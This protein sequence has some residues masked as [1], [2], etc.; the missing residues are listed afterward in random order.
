[1]NKRLEIL[2]HIAIWIV[3]ILLPLMFMNHGRGMSV[4]QFML[5]TTVPLTFM[6]VFYIDYLWLTPRYFVTGHRTQFFVI[7]TFIV[8]VLGIALHLWMSLSHD[9]LGHNHREPP[10]IL[11]VAFV[12]RDIVNLVIAAAIA[13][14]L[15]LALQWQTAE[16]ARKE[17]ELSNLRSQINPHFLLNTLNNIYALT[18]INTQ[19]AQEAIQDLSKMLR[20]MLYDYQRSEIELRD[21]VEFLKNYIRLMKL[22]QGP[23]VEVNTSF[24]ITNEQQKVAPMIFI[25]LVENAFKHGVKPAVPCTINITIQANDRQ[26]VCDIVNSNHPKT[27]TDRS[28]HGV[29]LELV[30][31]RLELAYKGRY[32]WTH[33]VN[34]NQKMYH[35]TITIK[36]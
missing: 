7:N 18:A 24:H 20:H 14:L 10:L 29:G 23:S 11:T 25:S 12:I 31:R 16:E 36:L 21:E 15:H 2:I 32:E 19:K 34:D 4:S 6:A 9:M 3:I 1:M 17:A 8:I 22:R 5:T 27:S 13:T 26:I 35:S 33:G 30:R 28:G